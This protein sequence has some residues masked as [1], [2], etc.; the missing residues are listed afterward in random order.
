MGRP[1]T[2]RPMHFLF[3]VLFETVF[4]FFPFLFDGRD[5]L[6]AVTSGEEG[7]GNR[8]LVSDWGNREL[9]GVCGETAFS[10]DKGIDNS[11]LAAGSFSI[12]ATR[13]S[14]TAWSRRVKQRAVKSVAGRKSPRSDDRFALDDHHTPNR[15]RR[16]RRRRKK[17]NRVANRFDSNR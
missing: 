16:E 6:F 15:R 10:L 14:C 17:K 13:R 9:N 1:K 8:R 7:G 2:A 3:A 4:R 11:F 12:K 5:T